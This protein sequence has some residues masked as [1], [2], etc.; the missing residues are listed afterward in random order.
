[1]LEDTT[2]TGQAYANRKVLKILSV[3][4]TNFTSK[5]ENKNWITWNCTW[6]QQYSYTSIVHN[7]GIK[8]YTSIVDFFLKSKFYNTC[9]K[10]IEIKNFGIIFDN[11]WYFEWFFLILPVYMT[12]FMTAWCKSKFTMLCKHVIVYCGWHIWLQSTMT[13]S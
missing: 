12:L 13:A 8:L 10:K 4:T 9:I 7:T 2:Y 1:M 5:R 11:K 6:R 3:K